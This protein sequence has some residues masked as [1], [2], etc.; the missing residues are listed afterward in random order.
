MN[1]SRFLEAGFDDDANEVDGLN[2]ALE[3]SAFERMG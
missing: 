3:L 1:L 2:D